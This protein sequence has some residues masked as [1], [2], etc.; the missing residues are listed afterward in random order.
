MNLHDNRLQA[1]LGYT[2]APA[3]HGHGYATE[4]VRAILG[5]LFRRGLHRVSAEC[6]ARNT[7]SAR[8]LERTVFNLEG[9]RPEFTLNI[10]TGEWADTLLYGLLA[11]HWQKQEA[12]S[13]PTAET[14]G[15]QH[16]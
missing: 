10:N 7:R 3:L 16:W 12:G 1:D 2:L 8:L 11:S 15:L 5:H 14:S 4:A 13:Q 6:D 9:R